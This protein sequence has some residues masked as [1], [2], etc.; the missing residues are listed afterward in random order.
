MPLTSLARPPA[1]NIERVLGDTS[2]SEPGFQEDLPICPGT[3]HCL[4]PSLKFRFPPRDRACFF[5]FQWTKHLMYGNVTPLSPSLASR[6]ELNPAPSPAMALRGTA[7]PAQITTISS[8]HLPFSAPV[9]CHLGSL[10]HDGL[11][12]FSLTRSRRLLLPNSQRLP[13]LLSLSCRPSTH[14]LRLVSGCLPPCIYNAV[15]RVSESRSQ[16]PPPPIAAVSR[17]CY[18]A[19]VVVMVFFVKYPWFLFRRFGIYV[20]A[21]CV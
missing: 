13:P 5:F 19:R 18:P 21:V 20:A 17:L 3:L 2:G 16:P 6:P 7:R 9:P 11:F 15:V 8:P 4:R 10:L 14:P 12:P 1:I